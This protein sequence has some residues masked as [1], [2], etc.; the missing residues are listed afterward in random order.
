MARSLFLLIILAVILGAEDTNAQGG[1]R[2][3]GMEW[4]TDRGGLD[5]NV[6][7]LPTPDPALCQD[8]CARDPRCM[9]WTYVQPNTFQGPRPRCWLKQAIPSPSGNPSCVSGYK[10]R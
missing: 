6:F 9:A 7:D 8:A 5:Y 1:Y 3:S 10:L 2:M 4:N